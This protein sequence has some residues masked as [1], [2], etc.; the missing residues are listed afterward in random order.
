MRQTKFK[1]LVA[2]LVASTYLVAASG[3]AQACTSMM[4]IDKNGNAYHGRGLEYSYLLPTSLTYTPA[5][6]LIESSTPTGTQG[7]TFNT[8]FPVL[9]LTIAALP[10]AK[11]PAL[12]QGANDQGLSFASN[13]LNDVSAPPVGNSP[14]KILSNYDLGYW[15][16]GNFKTVAEVKAAMTDGNTEFWIPKI[17]MMG[18]AQ[19]PQH[20]AVYDKKGGALVIEFLKGK[21]NVYDNPVG[22]LTN[23]PEFPWHLENLNNY[24]FNNL[25]KNTGQLGKLKLATQDAGIALAGLPSA[26]TAMGRFVKAAFYT[27]YV[28]KGK[29]A[30]EAINL[31]AHILNNFDR[32][33]D[34]T[35]D[36]PGGIGDGPRNNKTSSEVTN[37]LVMHDL[38]GNRSYFRSINALNWTVIDMSQLKD[39]KTTKTVSS[40]DVD[41]AGANAFSLFLK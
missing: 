15:I 33:Y 41:N 24:T 23:G 27:T 31:L 13:E 35:V 22:V 40:Y 11:Q 19:L 36:G 17:P 4:T 6:T 18:N 14:D 9:G 30:D 28:R 8:K 1:S 37:W 3:V 12:I 16:L 26:Q 25:D 20:Y 32:P 38:A 39:V 2:M 10:K 7:K 34:L 29:T 5:G 21:V